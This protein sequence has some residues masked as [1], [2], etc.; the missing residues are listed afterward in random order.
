MS[1]YQEIFHL[2]KDQNEPVVLA[3]TLKA[4][5]KE[6]ERQG[7]KQQ[8]VAYLEEARDLSF[9]GSKLLIAFVQSYLI[10]VYAGSGDKLH[11]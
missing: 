2:V 9:H 11:F 6:L 5:G 1:T 3:M 7:D 10:R 8:A 4:I